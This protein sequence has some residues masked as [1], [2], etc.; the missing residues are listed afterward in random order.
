MK[1][2]FAVHAATANAQEIVTTRARRADE[3][4]LVLWREG[5]I[6]AENAFGNEVERHARAPLFLLIGTAPTSTPADH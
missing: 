2:T 5:T 4:P 3:L 1:R 6:G